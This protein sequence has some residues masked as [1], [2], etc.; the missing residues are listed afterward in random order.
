[1]SYEG[2]DCAVDIFLSHVERKIIVAF[3]GTETN[4]QLFEEFMSGVVGFLD[5][6]PTGG[7]V[8]YS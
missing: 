3:R 1:M 8:S 6:Q 5:F 2:N 4:F 7:Q